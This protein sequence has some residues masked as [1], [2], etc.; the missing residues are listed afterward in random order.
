[1]IIDEKKCVIRELVNTLEN[2]KIHNLE[3]IA[4]NTCAKD[5][6]DYIR[7]LANNIVL[8][9]I[10]A[11][12][13]N[14]YLKNNLD[15]ID[16]KNDAFLI[17]ISP[18]KILTKTGKEYLIRYAH[19]INNLIKENSVSGVIYF[20]PFLMNNHNTRKIMKNELIN[21]GFVNIPYDKHGLDRRIRQY[22]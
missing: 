5:A 4:E 1:M 6:S 20:M 13:L 9:K 14:Y 16:Y 12:Q 19:K 17:I 18:E 2:I 8:E 22:L 11:L 10:N 7:Q 15:L 21:A 3:V